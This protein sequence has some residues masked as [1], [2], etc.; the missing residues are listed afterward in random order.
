MVQLEQEKMRNQLTEAQLQL[1]A[2]EKI[3]PLKTSPVGAK[4]SLVITNKGIFFLAIALGKILTGGKTVMSLSPQS[5]LGAKLIGS[6]AGETISI[7]NVVYV[8]EAVS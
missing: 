6:R 3:D 5:P 4:G 2:F 7:N 8:I 1:V